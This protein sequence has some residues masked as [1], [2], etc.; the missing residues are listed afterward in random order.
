[1]TLSE[2]G[3][4]RRVTAPYLVF[5]VLL[6]LPSLPSAQTES[7]NVWE[8]QTSP[9]S[10]VFDRTFFVSQWIGN[11]MLNSSMIVHGGIAQSENSARNDTWMFSY[12]LNAW[13]QLH[14]DGNS[15]MP[16]SRAFASSATINSTHV[17]VFGGIT[18]STAIADVF[19]CIHWYFR[20]CLPLV[21]VAAEQ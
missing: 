16:P 6:A 21:F 3:N 5:L 12:E 11:S 2:H 19:Y 8:T 13:F 14:G 9:Y 15:S 7:F 10:A 17:I 4:P 1:M 20:R 18:G